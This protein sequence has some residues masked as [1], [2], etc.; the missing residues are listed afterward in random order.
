MFHAIED[1]WKNQAKEYI[2]TR[3]H[4]LKH[5][6]SIYGARKPKLDLDFQQDIDEEY[7]KELI[8]NIEDQT[9]LKLQ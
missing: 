1:E 9:G 8:S 6:W 7:F 2:E 4:W 5:Y 3:F